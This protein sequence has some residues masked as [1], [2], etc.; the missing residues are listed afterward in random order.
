MKRYYAVEGRAEEVKV[1]TGYDIG[2]PNFLSGG[3]SRRGYYVYV[4][5]V[6]RGTGGTGLA[7]ERHTLFAGFKK[8]LFE[9]PR[10]SKAKAAQAEDVAHLEADR[11]AA[12]F[13]DEQG[14]TLTGVYEDA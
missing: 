7:F 1:S 12:Q 5:P 11:W 6:E 8:L 2:G 10:Q 13:A 9:V 14:W 4:Q 3:T